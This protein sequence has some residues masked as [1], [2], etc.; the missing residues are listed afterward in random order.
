MPIQIDQMTASIELVSPA[1][2]AERTRE[3]AADPG[4]AR[5]ALRD[6]VMRLLEDELARYARMR[7]H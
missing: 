2:A 4:V 3:V 5:D 7:G 1:P 6:V